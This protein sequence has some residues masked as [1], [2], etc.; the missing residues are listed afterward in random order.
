M[1][2]EKR[3]P[4]HSPQAPAVPARRSKSANQNALKKPAEAGFSNASCFAARRW[5]AKSRDQC[6]K[7]QNVCAEISANAA[8]SMI[9]SCLGE[10]RALSFAP[11]GA[12]SDVHAT[13][14]KKAGKYT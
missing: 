9:F 14:T 13:S 12:P 8:A 1:R 10:N 3:S 7:F 2:P 11:T 4:R 5:S 6:V